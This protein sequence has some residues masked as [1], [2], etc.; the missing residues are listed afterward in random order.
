MKKIALAAAALLATVASAQAADPGFYVQFLGG[1]SLPGVLEYD[2]DGEFDMDAGRALSGAVGYTVM[3]GLS[4]ELDVLH[5]ARTMSKY[6]YDVATTSLMGNVKYTVS[7]NDT[8]SVYGAVGVGYI[9]TEETDNFIDVDYDGDGFGYQLIA[10][11]GA[12]VTETV[13][14]IGEYRHQNTFDGSYSSDYDD[15]ISVPTNALLVGVK[16]GF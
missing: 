4:L 7:L 9:F 12:A 1:A 3:D 13:T 16:I 14:V 2:R 10:G 5:S 11:V 8:F 15:S 6:D